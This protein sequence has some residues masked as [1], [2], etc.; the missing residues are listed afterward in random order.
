MARGRKKQQELTTLEAYKNEIIRLK[1][2][3]REILKSLEKNRE[4]IRIFEEKVMQ[5]EH[6]EL[7]KL[8]EEKGITFDEVKNMISSIGKNNNSTNSENQVVADKSEE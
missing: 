1:I 2:V 7:M 6:R 8:I 4:Q 3:E 5:E